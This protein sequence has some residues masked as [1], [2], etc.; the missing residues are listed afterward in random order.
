MTI[1]TVRSQI[2]QY[3]LI[4]G[5]YII[6]ILARVYVWKNNVLLED[7]DSISYLEKTRNILRFNFK[8][9]LNVDSTPFYPF[10]SALFS[11]PG[12][13]VETGARLCS[14]F[15]S[16]LLL[17][18]IILIGKRIYEIGGV[19]LG[20][21]ILALSPILITLS[22]SVLTEPSY[23]ATIYLGIALYMFYYDNPSVAAALIMGVVFGFAFLNRI[24][25][26][27][28][29]VVIP[30]VHLLHALFKKY[31]YSDYKRWLLCNIIYILSFSAVIG[32]Q[33]YYI[34]TEMGRMAINGREAWSLILHNPDG[35][36][37]DE[38]I[39][40]LDY[41]D[42]EI[43]ILYVQRHPEVQRQ[44]LLNISGNFR[45]YLRNIFREY[46]ILHEVQLGILI[47]P[48]GFVFFAFGLSA[49]YQKQ[50]YY[51]ILLFL[52]FITV[53][54][55]PPLM[56]NVAMRHIAVI[57]PMIMLMEGIGIW[58]VSESLSHKLNRGVVKYIVAAMSMTLI[59]TTFAMPL[60]NIYRS[61]PPA[62]IRSQYYDNP[63]NYREALSVITE[64][65]E[66]GSRKRPVIM[67]R[68]THLSYFADG[69]DVPLP[70]TDYKGLVE[71]SRHNNVDYL[72]L[73]YCYIAAYPFMIKFNENN[74]PDFT[75]LHE[76]KD[77]QGH[78]IELYKV[79]KTKNG[80]LQRASRQREDE[81]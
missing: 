9:T 46:R 36:S 39:R 73:Q 12:W 40:G 7:H 28:F 48:L 5:V 43:N 20:L 76:T 60:Y 56:H 77:Y 27:L 37:Y 64:N 15:F 62:D 26:I 14:M 80:N 35:K 45:K 16:S 4:F 57:A 32:P 66:Q 42:K 69:I 65:P 53:F 70:H 72:Y 61:G 13:S 1:D 58:H 30:I 68:K 11:I 8:E 33:I 59:L 23:I 78:K 25:G 52:I 81:A 34:S 67:A 38:K 17:V 47:G 54:L 79:R 74:V 55:I 50:K 18:A 41:S 22:F 71:Y 24:E 2:K 10:F 21:I 44:L 49:L 75:I 19:V 6:Y 63:A 29:L 3:F 31:T 51:E